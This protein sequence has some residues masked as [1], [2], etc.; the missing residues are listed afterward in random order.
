MVLIYVDWGSNTMHEISFF[1]PVFSLSV[2]LVSN[3]GDAAA[4]ILNP[5]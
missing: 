4:M 2:C 3:G 1:L 5:I